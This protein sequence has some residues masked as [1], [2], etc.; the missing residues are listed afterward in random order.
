MILQDVDHVLSSVHVIPRAE[1][2]LLH[3]ANG[4]NHTL[5][6]EFCTFIKLQLAEDNKSAYLY[7][8]IKK[9][10]YGK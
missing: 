3:P 1:E 9:I 5:M 7:I 2:V 8:D 10:P 4:D 6:A